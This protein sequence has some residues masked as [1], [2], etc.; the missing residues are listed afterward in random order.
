MLS[1]SLLRDLYN[2][3]LQLGMEPLVEVNNT[4][5]ME[6]ALSLGAKVIG[7]NNRNLHDFKVDMNT[8]SRLSDMT[9]NKDVVL[10]A[11][12]GISSRQDV[13]RYKG[14]NIS[15]V[16]VGESLMRAK[17]A[18]AFISE[19]LGDSQPPRERMVEKPLVKICGIKT[20]DQA[21]AIADAGAD[22]IGLVFVKKSKRYVDRR[23][24]KEISAAIRARRYESDHDA[25]PTSLSPS[26]KNTTWFMTNA[27]RLEK[28]TKQARPLLVG[29]FQN[30]TLDEIIETVMDVQL[31]LVQLHGEEPV[32]WAS[33]IPVSVI[34]AFHLAPSGGK[35]EGVDSITR[36]GNHQ[37]ILLDSLREDGLSG[38]SGKVVDWAFARKV[39]DGGEVLLNGSKAYMGAADLSSTPASTNSIS[40]DPLPVILAG[41]LT[42]G[43]VSDAVRQV[44][45]WAVDVS[46]GVEMEGSSLKDVQKVK[47]FIDCVKGGSI[48]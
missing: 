39:V 46:G 20:R 27:K 3:A 45:P 15:A 28:F 41:G 33:Q 34:R 24:A 2:Y 38:G 1:E 21:V 9:R 32:D 14:Q 13:E 11:L 40:D 48:V 8:T 31:D 22:L 42:P 23:T 35:I 10:C 18:G 12:S 44:R 26:S 7:V 19:L 29:V 4:Q 16:L 43:N 6:I 5:E 17:D 47:A 25:V 37:F 36:P 30:S